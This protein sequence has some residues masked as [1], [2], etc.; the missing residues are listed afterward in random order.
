MTV[1]APALALSDRSAQGHDERFE[2]T[3]FKQRATQQMDVAG[4]ATHSFIDAAGR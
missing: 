4:A 2:P 3:R 1:A